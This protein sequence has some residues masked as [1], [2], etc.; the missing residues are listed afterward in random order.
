MHLLALHK[1]ARSGDG[2]APELQRLLSAVE[3]ESTDTSIVQL[4]RFNPAI[5]DVAGGFPQKTTSEENPRIRERKR[6]PRLRRP[7]G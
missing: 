4:R 6:Q 7:P 2:L 3:A 5:P 1:I